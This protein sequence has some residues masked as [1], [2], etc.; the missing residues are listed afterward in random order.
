MANL[1]DG[2]DFHDTDTERNCWCLPERDGD[3]WVHNPWGFDLRKV[4]Q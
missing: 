4:C 3:M 1:D 2:F